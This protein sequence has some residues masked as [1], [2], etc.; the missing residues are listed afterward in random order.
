MDRDTV[1]RF[2]TIADVDAQ[3][4]SVLNDSPILIT[5][6]LS[7]FELPFFNASPAL[8]RLLVLKELYR[9]HDTVDR[10]YTEL[11]RLNRSR[12]AT[13][14]DLEDFKKAFQEIVKITTNR[15]P[16]FRLV[17][18]QARHFL[19]L[20]CAPGGFATWLLQN[21]L[22][23]GVG[24][25][26]PPSA[27]I[28]GI[29]VQGSL[30]SLAPRFSVYEED[31]C[32][33]AR[34][35]STSIN[36]DTTEHIPPAGFDLVIANAAIM[37]AEGAVPRTKKIDLVYAQLLVALEHIAAGGTLVL[38]L[39]MR[40]FDWV[41]DIIAILRDSF[42]SVYAVKPRY[43]AK[44]S[45]AYIVCQSYKAN[46]DVKHLHLDHIRAII[47]YFNR[48]AIGDVDTIALPHPSEAVAGQAI[49]TYVVE[50]FTPVWERQYD[51][52][53]SNYDR[54][55]QGHGSGACPRVHPN[56]R[57][58][59]TLARI[60]NKN[61]QMPAARSTADH[62][63]DWRSRS[64]QRDVTQRQEEKNIGYK[65]LFNTPKGASDR[66]WR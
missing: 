2:K 9:L 29:S 30:Q 24:I 11:A 31:V 35:Q 54:V 17:L 20:G 46:A 51:A 63:S 58:E 64:A 3:I 34:G 18:D 49:L 62:S 47:C 42:D 37:L 45:F 15:Y 43:Q 1:S 41:I 19:D 10:T 5:S 26:L 7:N 36:W 40:P 13:P 21:T 55:L 61:P 25:T 14:S 39:W 59:S 12:T 60:G 32:S 56:Q 38:S 6:K 33:I 66:Q 52:I 16:A 65:K 28:P 23:H 27:S 57:S 22:M 50:L 8:R 44:T 53:R 4:D 48:T